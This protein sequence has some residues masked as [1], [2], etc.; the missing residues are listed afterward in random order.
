VTI[1]RIVCYFNTQIYNMH[2][3]T[4]CMNKIMHIEGCMSGS[5]IYSVN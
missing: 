5:V 4:R 3:A 1:I 2:N